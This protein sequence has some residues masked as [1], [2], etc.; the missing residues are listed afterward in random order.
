MSGSVT[1]ITAASR[2]GKAVK[3]KLSS[4][5]IDGEPE[6]QLRAPIE[7]LVSD[8]AELCGLPANVVSAIGET[9]LGDLKTRPDYAITLRNALA[10]FIEIKAPGKGGDPRRY[11]GHDAAQ[12]EK[13]QTLPNIIYTDGNCS[14]R[15]LAAVPARGEDHS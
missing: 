7:H 8:L 9:A 10:G 13:L 12:W 2:F 3:A 11:T 6:D 5:A 4:I 15:S 1:L 14:G